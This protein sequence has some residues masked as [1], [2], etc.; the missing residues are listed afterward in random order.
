MSNATRD[1]VTEQNYEG[2]RRAM[3]SNQLRTTAV[4]DPRVVDAMLS[5]PR[6]RHVPAESGPY[7]YIDR[8]IPLGNGRALNPP[9]ATGRLLTEAHAAPGERVLLIGSATGYAAALLAILGTQ[10]IALEED[11]ALTATAR[12]VVSS[13]A[14]RFVEGPLAAGWAEA[15][16]Y[17]LIFIDG[18]IEA[19]PDALIEQLSPN[20]RIATGIIDRG[21]T[22]LAIGRR[23]GK[24]FGPSAFAD[25]EIVTL[26]GFSKP[27]AFAF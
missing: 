20:G 24:G 16:P 1:G 27:K 11:A 13:A 10:V 4:N 22:R 15:A 23:A 17:D 14:V 18:A 25:A 7:A 21:V 3:V 19:I 5:V 9:M 26:P 2:M 8:A 12:A 6:E